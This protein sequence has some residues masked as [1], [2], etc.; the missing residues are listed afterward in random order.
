[1]TVNIKALLHMQHRKKL[2]YYVS[3]IVT[4]NTAKRLEAH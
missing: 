1:M 4:D 3:L 2:L